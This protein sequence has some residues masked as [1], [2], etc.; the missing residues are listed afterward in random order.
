MAVAIYSSGARPL[1]GLGFPVGWTQL[2]IA[3]SAKGN[4][5][6]LL[7]GEWRQWPVRL[8]YVNIMGVAV[9]FM[10]DLMNGAQNQSS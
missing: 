6:V 2:Q 4:V 10:G 7:M 1:G 9:L 5:A 3:M 8:A